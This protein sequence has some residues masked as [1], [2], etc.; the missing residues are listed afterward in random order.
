[1]AYIGQS[2][3]EG[4]RREYSYVATAG[5]TVFP[6]I[7]TVGAVDVH[8]NGILLPPSDYT[9]TDGTTV[10]FASGCAVNDEV[11]IH[12][13][14]TFSVADT[15]TKSASDDRFVNASGDTVNGDLTT[16]GT[17]TIGSPV[18]YGKLRV[19]GDGASGYTQT[20][21]NGGGNNI[22]RLESGGSPTAGDTAG[23]S[24]GLAGSAE[25]YIGAVQN[26]SGHAEIAF[27][28]YNGSYAERMRIDA[29]GRVTL[30]YQPMF[31]AYSTAGNI[32]VA[33]GYIFAYNQVVTNVGGS[34][35]AS[36]YRFT[37]PVT[38]SYFFHA[39]AMD[40]AD[41]YWYAAFY[42]NGSNTAPT[43]GS[44]GLDHRTSSVNEE[45]LNHTAILHLNA[46]DY[47]DF[48]IWAGISGRVDL[49]SNHSSFLGYL[50]G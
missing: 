17:H 6:A 18:A 13:H 8:Q 48:R 20:S 35:N 47:V 36:T 29:S 42:V 1:M 31:S 30:P 44:M 14:N 41:S 28:T 9:A 12:C 40:R 46:G 23:L 16:T 43:S 10:V 37:A 19:K 27:Q 22:I 3:T 45:M 49:L 15:Y 33:T 32:T 26:S 2:L 50:L 4:T 24:I 5:Q 11:V 25:A 7:Y 34:Y 39:S 21:F 38:G